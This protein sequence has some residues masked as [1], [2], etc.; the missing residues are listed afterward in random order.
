METIGCIF[1]RRYNKFVFLLLIGKR[2]GSV[3]WQ[4]QICTFDVYVKILQVSTLHNI[5]GCWQH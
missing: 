4:S 2:F 5:N 1:G 3:A